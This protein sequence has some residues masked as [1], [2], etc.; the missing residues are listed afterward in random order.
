MGLEDGADYVEEGA[1]PE[2]GDG[3]RELTP[4]RFDEKEDEGGS[5]DDLDDTIDPGGEKR[6]GR[7]RVSDLCMI[8][9]EIE[10]LGGKS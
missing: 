2:G 8:K 5:S 4:E 1:H 6:L 10:Q 7:S 3:E 9:S